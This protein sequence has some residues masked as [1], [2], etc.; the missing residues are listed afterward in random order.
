MRNALKV[1]PLKKN[2]QKKLSKR[3]CK[4]T[5]TRQDVSQKMKGSRCSRFEQISA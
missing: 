4:Q 5:E 1:L 2:A 3:W